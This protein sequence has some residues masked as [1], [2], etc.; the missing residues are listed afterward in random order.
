MGKLLSDEAAL[1]AFCD[2]VRSGKVTQTTARGV[3]AAIKNFLNRLTKGG[4]ALDKAAQAFFGENIKAARNAVAALEQA[5]NEATQTSENKNAAEDG[6][7]RYNR[8]RQKAEATEDAYAGKDLAQDSSVYDYDFMTSLHDMDIAEMPPLSA[9]KVDGKVSAK[10]AA[11]LGMEDAAQLG[12]VLDDDTV[13]VGNS[14]TGREVVVSKNALRHS[15]DGDQGRLRTNARLSSIA[16]QL[17][18]NAVPINALTNETDSVAG[19]YAMACLAKSGER[20]VVAIITVESRSN[21][22]VGIDSVDIAHS[23]SGRM[24]KNESSLPAT[25][26]QVYQQ[27]AATNATTLKLSIADFLRIV[28]GTHQSILSADVLQHFGE[29]R[30]VDGHYA[31][32]VKFS[33]KPAASDKAAENNAEAEREAETPTEKA[34]ER[35][36]IM[37]KAAVREARERYGTIEPGE[38]PA[39]PSN[40]PR[41]MN[42]GTKV[43]KTVRTA[44]EATVTPEGLIPKV[45]DKLIEGVFNYKPKKNA[46]LVAEAHEWMDKRVDA[47]EAYLDWKSDMRGRIRSEKI[48]RG[49]VLYNNLATASENVTNAT[50]KT[51]LQKAAVDVLQE[52]SIAQHDNASALQAQKRKRWEL[53]ACGNSHFSAM[54]IFWNASERNSVSRLFVEERFERF[55]DIRV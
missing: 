42:E 9:V 39:R 38:N 16:G 11:E 1:N 31:D 20:Y 26:A 36:P 46:E 43:T 24:V 5:A 21:E 13:A 18:H 6:D 4:R 3:G 48:A 15:I 45:E 2:A 30:N 10:K 54:C 55:A 50:E 7:V 37:S 14:Y 19:T 12:K 33:K 40:I 32:R 25:R 23:I 34:P 35:R 29:T 51:R 49:W 27:K 22:V 41:K 17:M 47:W 53:P 44:A 8:Q 52:L 28:K